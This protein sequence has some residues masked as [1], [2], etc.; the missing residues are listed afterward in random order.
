M[1]V[2]LSLVQLYTIVQC[3][4]HPRET[5]STI[6]GTVLHAFTKWNQIHNLNATERTFPS[7]QTNYCQLHIFFYA[8][9]I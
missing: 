9:N 7:I 6:V 2:I 1:H 3:S 5:S 8:E 4:K